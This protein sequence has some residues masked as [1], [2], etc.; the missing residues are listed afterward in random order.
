VVVDWWSG[1]DNFVWQ[2]VEPRCC[3]CQFVTSREIFTDSD[4]KASV[5]LVLQKLFQ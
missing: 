4:L 3:F 2:S 1:F 5:I